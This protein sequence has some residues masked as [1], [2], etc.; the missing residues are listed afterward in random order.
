M[1]LVDSEDRPP[2]IQKALA[3]CNCQIHRSWRDP[4]DPLISGKGGAKSQARNCMSSWLIINC[5]ADAGGLRNPLSGGDKLMP[6][7][8]KV[9][10]NEGFE[11]KC[12]V[13][14]DA[15]TIMMTQQTFKLASYKSP[16]GYF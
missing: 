11:G 2:Q 13:S 4:F 1:Y 14:C 9:Y 6:P 15:A 7:E 8:C 16:T 3:Q 10:P 12:S 5:R